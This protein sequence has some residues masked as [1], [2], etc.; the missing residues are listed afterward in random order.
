VPVSPEA[1]PLCTV[2]RL[3]Y[4]VV[5][6]MLGYNLSRFIFCCFLCLMIYILLI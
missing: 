4:E 2:N 5:H 1:M 3:F 6:K